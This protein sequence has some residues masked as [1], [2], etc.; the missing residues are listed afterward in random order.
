M[1]KSLKL[2]LTAIGIAIAFAQPATAGEGKHHTIEVVSDYDNLRMIF[3]PKRLDIQPGDTVTWENMAAEEHNVFSYPDGFPK[4]GKA[5][6]SHYMQKKGEKWSFKF[7][8]PGTYEYHCIPHLPMGMHGK[9]VVGQAS[10]ADDFHVPSAEEMKKYS[11]MLR[12]YFDDDEFKY[13]PRRNRGKMKQSSKATI[14]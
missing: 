11:A 4:G 3:K 6:Q 8:V 1:T 2:G 12:E 5:M 10:K 13:K 7:D 9:V 14:K